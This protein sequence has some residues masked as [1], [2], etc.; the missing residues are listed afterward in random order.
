MSA[1]RASLSVSGARRASGR[2]MAGERREEGG[3]RRPLFNVK[4][5]EEER[6]E[7][8]KEEGRKGGREEQ[9]VH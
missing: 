8:A 7:M 3:G 4:C 5:E 9:E 1:A 2:A 6:K